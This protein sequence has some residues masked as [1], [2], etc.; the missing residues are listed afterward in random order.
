MVQVTRRV[1]T[2]PP[3]DA[4]LNYYGCAWTNDLRSLLSANLSDNSEQAVTSLV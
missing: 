1:L 4:T 2:F 3:T